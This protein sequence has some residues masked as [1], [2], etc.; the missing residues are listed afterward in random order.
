[1]CFVLCAFSPLISAG[2]S[3][4]IARPAHAACNI[5]VPVV[6][7]RRALPEG[8]R[9][10]Q[11]ADRARQEV[12]L[13]AAAHLNGRLWSRGWRSWRRATALRRLTFPA[14][15]GFCFTF[16]LFSLTLG[17]QL[18]I[19]LGL[20]LRL[21]LGFGFILWRCA[22]DACSWGKSSR[23]RLG[24]W[25]RCRSRRWQRLRRNGTCRGGGLVCLVRL[26]ISTTHQVIRS[27][28]SCQQH[29]NACND[30]AP[31]LARRR[32]RWCSARLATTRRGL[33]LQAGIQR[34]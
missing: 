19:A 23:V 7:I 9:S 3:I 28:T 32:R 18:C 25:L 17:A 22:G 8:G 26:A 4:T 33:G 1:M 34:R 30:V 31:H 10:F 13:A 24:C 14:L 21:C 6:A 5:V 16:G 20:G 12:R 15:S 2:E 29:Q 27:T 11:H